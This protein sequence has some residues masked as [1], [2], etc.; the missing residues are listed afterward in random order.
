MVSIAIIDSESNDIGILNVGKQS[1]LRSS[2]HSDPSPIDGA[3]AT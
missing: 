1:K 2:L 3:S